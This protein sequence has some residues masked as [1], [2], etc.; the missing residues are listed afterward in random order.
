MDD[1][2][3]IEAAYAAWNRG[4]MDAFVALAHPGVVWHGSGAF[5]G[6]GL[7][8]DGHDGIRQLYD[9][10]TGP[11][12]RFQIEVE[13]VEPGDGLHE[14]HIRM[15]AVGAESGVPVH[16]R[17]INEVSVDGGLIRTVRTRLQ[18]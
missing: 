15:E 4:D 11:F 7:R 3:V 13:R 16:V 9:D 2:D 10:L 18:G 12:S 5:P 1:D 8:Y 6:L 14:V 17:F